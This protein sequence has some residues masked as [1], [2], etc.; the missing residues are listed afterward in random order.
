MIC[1]WSLLLSNN[2]YMLHTYTIFNKQE[3]T[4]KAE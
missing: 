4:K 1:T 3:E 2:V